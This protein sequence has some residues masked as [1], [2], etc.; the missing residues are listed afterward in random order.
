MTALPQHAS[1]AVDAPTPTLPTRP[2]VDQQAL[3]TARRDRLR[4]V[5]DEIGVHALVLLTPDAVQYA[6]GYRS[7]GAGL[8]ATHRMAAVLTADDCWL[9][10]PAGDAGAAVDAGLPIERIVPFGTFFFESVDRSPLSENVGRHPHLEA[11]V[12]YVVGAVGSAGSGAMRWGVDGLSTSHEFGDRVSL[13]DAT[14]AVARARRE[15]LPAEVDL[16]R[17]AA[18]LT[19]AAMASAVAAAGAGMTEKEIADH[20]AGVM[21]AGG[22][23][24]RFVVSGTGTR[25][26][27]SDSFASERT[28][29]PGEILRFDAGCVVDGYWSDLGRT[30]V[31]D[32]PSQ[33]QLVRYEA[34]LAGQEAAFELTRS[35]ATGRSLF[36]AAV[37]TVN[38]RGLPY[39]RHH[40][41]HGIGLSIYER[42]SVSPAGDAPIPTGSTLCIETPYYELGWGGMMVED[43]VL[44]TESGYERLNETDRRLWVAEA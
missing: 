43:T 9:V 8:Y 39:R 23:E 19:E 18:L 1:I 5:I 29:Q 17:Y 27:L 31:L 41:G 30:V 20:V 32:T 24:P 14:D 22:G 10:C 4:R 21:V 25:S 38:A 40:C 15:K 44:V 33:V 37:R 16:L 34:I 12:R 36:E 42:P 35:G 3:A 6:T 11:A 28:W 2:V 26:A 13:V 7:V